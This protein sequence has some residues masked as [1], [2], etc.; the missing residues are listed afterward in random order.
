[1]AAGDNMPA[2]GSPSTVKRASTGAAPGRRESNGALQT[3]PSTD[4]KYSGDST[5]SSKGI[6]RGALLGLIVKSGSLPGKSVLEFCEKDPFDRINRK[7]KGRML[8]GIR[9]V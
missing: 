4:E 1:M 2:P 3:R 8:T 6:C 5:D 9:D 7:R